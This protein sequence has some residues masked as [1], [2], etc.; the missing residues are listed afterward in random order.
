MDAVPVANTRMYSATPEVREAWKVLLRWV[1]ARAGVDVCAQGAQRAG[2]G[3][4]PVVHHHLVHDVGE[5]QLHRTHRAV[6]DD[7]GAFLDP[8]RLE[9]GRRFFKP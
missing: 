8:L 4:A 6:G 7:T 2:L 5:R 9:H 3:L 1:L